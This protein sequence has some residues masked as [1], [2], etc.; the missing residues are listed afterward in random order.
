MIGRRLLLL[1]LVPLHSLYGQ[2]LSARE[3]TYLE[4][5]GGAARLTERICGSCTGSDRSIGPALLLRV[6]E[7]ISPA[8]ARRR[9][10]GYSE[11]GTAL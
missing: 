1:I 4:I 8:F 2:R 7:R 5:G 10:P 11:R 3:G 9:A 6:G